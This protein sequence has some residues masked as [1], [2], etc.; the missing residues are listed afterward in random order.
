MNVLIVDCYDSFT[1]NLYQQVGRLGGAP[2]WVTCDTPLDAL[3]QTGCDRSS[4]RPAPDAG[5]YRGLPGCAYEHEPD[6]PHARGLPRTPG[7]LCSVWGMVGRAERLM[8]GKASQIRHDGTG[9]YAGIAMP[10]TAARYHS[11]VAEW[12]A[13]PLTWRS[14]QPAWMTG[15]S[16]G[17]GTGGSRSRAS[18]SIPRASSRGPGMQSLQISCKTGCTGHDG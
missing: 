3:E 4:S 12:R 16:W 10:F 8:H 14:W 13:C 5:G 11:L 7:D 6:H 18:S 9:I 17:S 15:M 2:V 1:F